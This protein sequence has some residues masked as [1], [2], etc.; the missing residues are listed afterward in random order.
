MPVPRVE[1]GKWSKERERTKS[2]RW[3]KKRSDANKSRKKP[4]GLKRALVA[5]AA[6]IVILVVVVVLLF[7]QWLGLPHI[8]PF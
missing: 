2:G 4:S 1:D 6:I 8:L 7:P 3:R 5:L